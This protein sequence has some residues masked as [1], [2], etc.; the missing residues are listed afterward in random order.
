MTPWLPLLLVLG[1]FGLPWL[2]DAA[3]NALLAG[4]YL[5]YVAAITGVY[6]LPWISARLDT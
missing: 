2:Q 3:L 5:I 6:F 4:L 1:G